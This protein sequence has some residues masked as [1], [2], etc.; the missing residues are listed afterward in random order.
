MYYSRI[1]SVLL[2]IKDTSSS[3]F[4]FEFMFCIKFRHCL[5]LHLRIPASF[6]GVRY[7]FV[8]NDIYPFLLHSKENYPKKNFQTFFFMISYVTKLHQLRKG[9]SRVKMTTKLNFWPSELL[10]QKLIFCF[11]PN[12]IENLVFVYVQRSQENYRWRK[13]LKSWQT[14]E[15]KSNTCLL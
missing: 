2:S 10:R 4:R 12:S 1:I 8:L 3:G 11:D 13:I 15:A 6:G 5:T 9:E 14:T 7:S